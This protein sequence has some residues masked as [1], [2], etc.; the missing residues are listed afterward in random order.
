MV[1]PSGAVLSGGAGIAATIVLTGLPIFL[2]SD[3]TA[4]SV[5]IAIGLVALAGLVLWQAF[6]MPS[7]D[8][9]SEPRQTA[10]TRGPNSPATNVARDQYNL[11]VPALAQY[12]LTVPALAP[13]EALSAAQGQL[14][15]SIQAWAT[16]DA[17]KDNELRLQIHEF[18]EPTDR[19]RAIVDEHFH[20]RL[21]EVDDALRNDGGSEYEWRRAA[22]VRLDRVVGSILD[23]RSLGVAE[24]Q[25]RHE[26]GNSL[27][28]R[29][30]AGRR[31][32]VAPNAWK[33]EMVAAVRE[34]NAACRMTAQTYV[35]TKALVMDDPFSA[36][37]A[38]RG[39]RWLIELRHEVAVK[40]ERM[41]TLQDRF[42][43]DSSTRTAGRALESHGRWH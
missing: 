8:Q 5:L 16:P 43:H 37:P 11:T 9:A 33:T 4:G 29:L 20:D 24:F 12:N 18:R 31:A 42:E 21:P 1:K 30:K 28:R 35:P 19:I 17:F 22:L 34:W 41:N 38:G 40:I 39:E 10:I 3:R 36:A 6:G 13:E 26:E 32:G 23:R 2:S 27:A 14:R 25:Q 15:V 7:K